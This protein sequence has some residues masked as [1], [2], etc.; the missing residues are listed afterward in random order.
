MITALFHA[1]AASARL[2]LLV[3][4]VVLGAQVQAQDVLQ[5]R[6]I[7]VTSDPYDFEATVLMR[8]PLPL[9]FGGVLPTSGEQ[10][11]RARAPFLQ[12]KRQ[13]GQVTYHVDQAAYE[14][15]FDGFVDYLLK[16]YRFSVDG[17]EIEPLLGALSLVPKKG[18]VMPPE[19]YA[20]TLSLVDIC[21][22]FPGREAVADLEVVLLV[23]LPDTVPSD[24]LT[25]AVTAPE[26]VLSNTPGPVTTFTDHRGDALQSVVHVG[27]APPAVVMD[28]VQDS[29]FWG[30][31]WGASE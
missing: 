28:G 2:A 24:R 10:T 11:S 16:D 29:G 19:G 15:D 9:V 1:V 31:L 18:A 22:A 26:G 20:E 5:S 17:R 14:D 30:W 4:A 7:H 8:F 21:T 3:G 23:Y 27:F 25:I 6:E 13:D 12:E